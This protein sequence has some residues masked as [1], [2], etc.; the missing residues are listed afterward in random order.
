[1][2]LREMA[3]QAAQEKQ[4]ENNREAALEA[5]KYVR[6]I[7]GVEATPDF[8]TGTAEVDGLRF[9]A[10]GAGSLFLAEQAQWAKPFYIGSLHG[11]GRALATPPPTP[12]PPSVEE[13]LARIADELERI[14]WAL[15]GS[16]FTVDG[17]RLADVLSR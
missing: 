6:R 5:V 15:N 14:R 17:D 11:L 1:M 8:A 3:A 2:N 13:S 7:F 16:L 4:Q 12:P 9:V 10:N